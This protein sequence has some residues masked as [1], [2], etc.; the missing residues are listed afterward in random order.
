MDENQQ[1]QPAPPSG[2]P[3]RA[4]AMMQ[5]LLAR[6]R[7]MEGQRRLWLLGAGGLALLCFLG[8]LWFATRTDWKTLYAGLEPSDA[9]EIAS[10]LT[11]ANIPFD[12]SPDGTSLRVPAANLDKARLATTAK[13]GPKSGRMGFELFDKPNWI[14]SEFDEKVNYQRALE[15][16]LEHTIN[17]L[18]EV[19][20][21]RVHLVMPHDSLYT[22]QQRDAKASV[23]LKLKRRSLSD[24]QA[25]AIRNLVASAVDDLHP[26][27]VA[28]VDAEGRLQ[29]GRHN[30][31]ADAAAHEQELAAKLVETLEPVAGVGNVRASV[32]VDYDSSSAD[33]V[34]ETYDPSN[35]VTLSMQRS[36]QT[37]GAQSGPTGVPGTASNAPNVQPPLFP[38]Q[39]LGTQN[40]RQESG[41]YGASKRVRHTVQGTGKLRRVT[42]AVLIN[43]RM[44]VNGKL[45]SWQSR[46]PEEMQ[47]LTELAQAAI[48]FDSARGDTV[49]VE[50]MAFEDNSAH[51]PAT[52]MEQ[53]LAGAAQSE[54]MWKYSALVAVFLCLVF[55]V[56]RPAMRKTEP[57]QNA[58]VGAPLAEPQL[59]SGESS[60]VEVETDDE[61]GEH[62]KKR[63]QLVFD[64]VAEHLRREPAQTARLLQSWIHTE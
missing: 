53:F 44:L 57:R 43:H 10:E 41:T 54:P 46:T 39:N 59:A 48:G 21:S 22:S 15:G 25:D 62:R 11:A 38:Q 9:R 18:S 19:E 47:H 13:G 4:S 36:D 6:L 32:N 64:A 34:D 20:S 42:A 2:L 60:P 33:E 23:V 56:L 50:D 35:V 3:H 26:E 28:L 7:G 5:G 31:S 61:A 24:E 37:S 17:T 27:D 45:V 1:M 30:A 49:S 58:A 16:E 63:A 51:P 52:A 55:F 14:G 8:I 12:V 29:L 40:L